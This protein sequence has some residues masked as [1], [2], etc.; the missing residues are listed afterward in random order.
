MKINASNVSMS[1]EHLAGES[2]EINHV[3]IIT[4]GSGALEKIS[5]FAEQHSGSAV[6]GIIE[7]SDVEKQEAEQRKEENQ[8]NL[9]R[10]LEQMNENRMQPPLI[11]S[12]DAD[13]QITLLRKLL[14]ALNGKGRIDPVELPQMKKDGILDLRSS[15]FRNL[16]MALSARSVSGASLSLSVS[17]KGG[18]A[19][20]A[21]TTVSGTTWQ[22]ITATS[23][24]HNESEYTSFASTGLA[25]TED[26][27]KISFGVEFSMARN[28]SQKFE[29][30]TSENI[31]LTDPLIINIDSKYAGL[32]DVKFKFDLDNDGVKDD[33]SFAAEGSGFLA[34]DKDGNGTIDNGS[35]LF[36]TSSGDGFK[37][38][39]AYDEDGNSWIDE[40]DAVYSKL[41]VWTKDSEGNDK[42][43]DLKEANVGAIYLGSAS[44]EF[45]IKNDQN[46]LQGAVRKTGIY[47]KETGEVGTLQHVDL[48]M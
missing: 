33:I 40:N 15:N 31:I 2:T 1:S 36:G 26:G 14:A 19:P 25:L 38:L 39:A 48:A 18:T 6:A 29:S 12:D 46:A 4:R 27:R 3:S 23:G 5:A 45:S 34:L 9:R 28:F 30:I 10:M 41:R 35:E 37:D 22:K 24:Y 16:E 42:L 11:L 21:G 20:S 13:M 44:T 7:Y 32:T 8:N 43:L 47:L 17:G